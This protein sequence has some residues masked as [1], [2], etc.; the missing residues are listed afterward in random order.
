ME[1]QSC[2]YSLFVPTLSISEFTLALYYYFFYFS[3]QLN[4]TSMFG[5]E[6]DDEPYSMIADATTPGAV[7]IG[8]WSVIVRY[9]SSG[10]KETVVGSGSVG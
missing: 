2:D 7:L 3:S 1:Y 4:F 8:L 5:Y 10:N 9:F 6:V